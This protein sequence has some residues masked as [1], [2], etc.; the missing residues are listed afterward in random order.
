MKRKKTDEQLRQLIAT[1]QC[2]GA[3]FMRLDYAKLY[4]ERLE[5]LKTL[6]RKERF[7]MFPY[8]TYDV[9]Q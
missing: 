2:K 1:R 6:T 4:R 9:K 5:V 7:E 3:G 8:Y